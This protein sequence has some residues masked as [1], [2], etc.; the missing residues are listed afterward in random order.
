MLKRYSCSEFQCNLYF[1]FSEAFTYEIDNCI[2]QYSKRVTL[3]KSTDQNI[4]NDND[5]NKDNLDLEI[6]EMKEALTCPLA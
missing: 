1:R 2:S 4:S 6:N 3:F 5:N